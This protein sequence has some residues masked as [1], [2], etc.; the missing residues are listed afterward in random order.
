MEEVTQFPVE[1]EGNQE[2][3]VLMKEKGVSGKGGITV[4][5]VCRK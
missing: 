4:H 2:Y 1:G 3:T 5:V